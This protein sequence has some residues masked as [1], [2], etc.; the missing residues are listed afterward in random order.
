MPSYRERIHDEL[1]VAAHEF[2]AWVDADDLRS[3]VRPENDLSYRNR[4]AAMVRS[5]D[6]RV[7]R[8]RGRG[9]YRY[10]LFTPMELERFFTLIVL[11]D[12]RGFDVIA[13]ARSRRRVPSLDRRRRC[14]PRW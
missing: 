4:L 6:A 8:S 5:G 3:R 14:R 11:A 1:R 13:G 10:A 7:D 12:R 9:N 2:D